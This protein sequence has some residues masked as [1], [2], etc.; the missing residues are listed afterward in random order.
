[1]LILTLGCS[2]S[3]DIPDTNIEQPK[4]EEVEIIAEPIIATYLTIKTGCL[5]NYGNQGNWIIVYDESGN[6]IDYKA[7]QENEIIT[8]ESDETET[9]EKYSVTFL[10]INEF[11]GSVWNRLNTSTEVLMGSTLDYSCIEENNASIPIIG[12]FNVT[13]K[14]VP[15]DLTVTSINASNGENVG[16]SFSESSSNGL[17]TYEADLNILEAKTDYV[18]TIQ[19][20]NENAKYYELENY[21]IG[22]KISINYED[23][24]SYTDY[25]D[26]NYPEHT[27][28][29]L[30][31]HGINTNEAYSLSQAFSNGNS[32]GS[33]RLGNLNRFDTYKVLYEIQPNSKYAY[34]FK[35]TGEFPT[36]II[37]PIQPSITIADPSIQEFKFETSL[38]DF[39]SKTTLW[40]SNPNS[41]HTTTWN[42]DSSANYNPTISELPEEIIKKNPQLSLN[43]LEYSQTMFQLNFNEMITIF[44]N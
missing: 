16:F 10:T 35:S 6:L 32:Q 41:D 1:M 21:E 11:L 33:L 31:L 26:I 29:R 8:F 27:S 28:L 39:Q 17:M 3:G 13:I 36:E 18:I 20:G 19:D 9:H 7:F 5:L 15:D 2:K 37:T 44:H 24:N 4:D 34:R 30:L 12:N 38:S 22:E 14:N 25:I 40:K 42:I 23:F 43:N